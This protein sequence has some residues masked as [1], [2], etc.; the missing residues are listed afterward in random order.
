MGPYRK[1]GLPPPVS[2]PW[3]SSPLLSRLPLTFTR[4][5]CFA[6]RVGRPNTFGPI[7]CLFSFLPCLWC[8]PRRTFRPQLSRA[9]ANWLRL[10]LLYFRLR[11]GSGCGSLVRSLTLR[12]RDSLLA[13][14]EPR[15]AACD[16]DARQE[17]D[18]T[19]G[20]PGEGPAFQARHSPGGAAL[21][22]RDKRDTSRAQ[23]RQGVILGE[24]LPVLE[25]KE[26]AA[27]RG[28]RPLAEGLCP[29]C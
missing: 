25:K 13:S 2:W 28:L 9:S 26:P 19:L 14:C 6:Q 24:G 18:S 11:C 5:C 22:P 17:F 23:A 3:S 12:P 7:A 15:P 29:L 1:A 16:P 27:P 20:Y 21:L 8:S 4:A 10:G